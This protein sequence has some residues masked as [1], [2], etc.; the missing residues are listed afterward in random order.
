[1]ARVRDR[2]DRRQL[3][4]EGLDA[5]TYQASRGVE[6]ARG[7]GHVRRLPDGRRD[8]DDQERVPLDAGDRQG[9]RRRDHR[10]SVESRSTRSQWRRTSSQGKTGLPGTALVTFDVKGDPETSRRPRRPSTLRWRRSRRPPRRTREFRIKWYGDAS[11]MKELDDAFMKDLQKAE[12]LS[13]PFTLLILLVAFGTFVAAGVPI[14]LALSAVA[15]TMGL[16]APPSHLLPI[17]DSIGVGDPADRAGGGG[18]LRP[19]YIR[20]EREERAAGKG[21]RRRSRAAAATSGRAVLISGLTVMTAMA[22]MSL[23]ARQDIIGSV[24]AP[25]RSW[26]WAWRWS[27]R[28]GPP[29]LLTKLGRRVDKGRVPLAGPSSR[30]RWPRSALGRDRRSRPAAPLVSAAVAGGPDRIGDPGARH[31]TPC[32]RVGRTT[33]RTWAIQ[34]INGINEAFPGKEMAASGRRS[35]TARPVAHGDRRLGSASSRTQVL[36]NGPMFDRSRAHPG[37]RQVASCRSRWR[38]PEATRPPARAGGPARRRRPGH[39]VAADRRREAVVTGH[40]AATTKDFNDSMK[41]HRRTCSAWC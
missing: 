37:R 3:G 13:L 34:P 24:S 2:R 18:R 41:S 16:V 5:D 40:A 25:G 21:T 39:M 6:Q 35:R 28:D 7:D 27:A 8:R 14:L 29:A 9:R 26:S 4:L 36:E 12:T 17:D 15:A 11:S 31:D 1:M 33:R 10:P 20:R 38:G 32:R 23:P 19:F 22:G 30:P